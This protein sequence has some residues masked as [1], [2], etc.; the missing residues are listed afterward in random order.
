M[1]TDGERIQNLKKKIRE[2]EFDIDD[3]LDKYV[4]EDEG[5][6]HRVSMFWECT[7]SPVGYCVYTKWEDPLSDNCVYCH[8][9]HERG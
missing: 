9:P 3:I 1:Y 2:I 7:E 5:Q 8:Q 6:W 4:G